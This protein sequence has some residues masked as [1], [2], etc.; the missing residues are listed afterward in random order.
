MIR[1][2]PRSTL[3]P[4]TTLFRS[5][6]YLPALAIPDRDT[7]NLKLNTPPSFHNPKSVL[8]VALPAVDSAKL[9]PLHAV[10]PK[11]ISCLQKSPLVLGV[12]GAPLVFSTA[13]AH[14]FAL[15]VDLKPGQTMELPAVA[16]PARGGFVIDTKGLPAE[17]SSSEITGILHGIWGFQP[18]DG[19]SFRL[20]SA[21]SA[22][23]SLA[24]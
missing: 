19:P 7:L 18:F 9:P 2:P 20:Q 11:Q 23:W 4:Y 1:R 21:H 5:F 24:A 12:D 13:F 15:R 3:F 8:V 17:K 10:D 14:D 22:R 6:Q 16:D